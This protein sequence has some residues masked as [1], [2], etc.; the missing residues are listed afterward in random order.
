MTLPE[1]LELRLRAYYGSRRLSKC[2]A[3][4]FTIFRHDLFDFEDKETTESGQTFNV[5]RRRDPAFYNRSFAKIFFEDVIQL[6]ASIFRV[7]ILVPLALTLAGI[8]AIV[9][10]G[11]L[12]FGSSL[13]KRELEIC[14][15]HFDDYKHL[16]KT[17]RE[18]QTKVSK[19]QDKF[20]DKFPLGQRSEQ[21]D[22]LLLDSNIICKLIAQCMENPEETSSLYKKVRI[23]QDIALH[24][25]QGIMLEGI[26]NLQTV[27]GQ[28]LGIYIK[29]AHL[30]THPDNLRTS[31]NAGSILKS[32]GVERLWSPT[33]HIGVYVGTSLEYI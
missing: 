10:A 16:G 30:A 25:I 33:Q 6:I 8:G 15:V 31:I 7:I 19:K 21:E 2:G 5:I 3:S 27:S 32:K 22:D 28:S 12:Y 29:V 26:E 18:W 9:R 11:R 1:I 23:C 24:A 20:R 17:A 13:Q 14:R 4:D